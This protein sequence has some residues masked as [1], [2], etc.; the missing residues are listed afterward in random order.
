MN[1]SPEFLN[2]SSAETGFSQSTLEKA[3]RLGELATNISRHPL[4]GT[5]LALKGGTALNL[6]FGPPK[7]LSADLDFNYIGHA[8][9]D[10]MLAH[11]SEVHEAVMQLAGR[12]R[13]QTQESPEGFAGGKIF[14]GYRSAS[15]NRDRIELDLN[16]LYRVPLSG[17]S[18]RPLWQPDELDPALVR[19]VGLPELLIGKLLAFLDRMAARDVWDVANLPAAANQALALPSFRKEFIAF[20]AVLV[21]PLGSYTRERLE[22]SVTERAIADQVLPMLTGEARVDA[23]DLV[24]RAWDVIVPFLRLEPEEK[25]YVEGIARGEVRADLLFP[26]DLAKASQIVTHPAIEWKL[27]NVIKYRA[28]KQ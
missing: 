2:R 1:L 6:C 23:V 5:V 27:K 28:G 25:Q 19:V 11:R 14:L 4:L 24:T 18:M 15:G 13:Y 12:M 8:E 7:R 10:A 22:R 20:S 16:Y 17:T 26:V 3:I 21:H 9:R